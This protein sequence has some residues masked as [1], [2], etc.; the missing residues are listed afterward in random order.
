LFGFAPDPEYWLAPFHPEAKRAFLGRVTVAPDLSLRASIVPV[1]V[2]PPGRP[3][4]AAGERAA[5][6]AEYL[7]SITVAAGLPA[8]AVSAGGEVRLAA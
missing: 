7:Q 5:E 3:V 2:E 1:W 8:V 6:I 4:L